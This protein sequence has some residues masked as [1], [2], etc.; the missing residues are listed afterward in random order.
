MNYKNGKIYK[1][2][3]NITGEIYIGSCITTLVKRFYQH[4][5]KRNKCSSK[6]ITDRGDCVIVLI[7]AFP[8]DNKSE[9]FQRERYHYDLI[10]NINR[11]RPFVTDEESIELNRERVKAH[12]EAN[13]EAL[14]ARQKAYNEV[15]K[16]AIATYHKKHYEANKEA[17]AA[18]C[19]AYNEK[20]KVAIAAY[21]KARYQ[22]RKAAANQP[23]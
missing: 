4:K 8:C 5:H 10:P 7:E 3:C 6:Q 14:L 1:I 21:H 15:N 12:Y 22:A 16:E 18:K 19:K 11:N 2:V 17:V 20:N 9:L 23:S 13:T